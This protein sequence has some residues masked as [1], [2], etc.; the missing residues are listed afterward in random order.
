MEHDYPLAPGLAVRD[1][2]IALLVNHTT[3][4]ALA[5]LE[6]PDHL[7]RAMLHLRNELVYADD[8]GSN[9]TLRETSELSP[10]DCETL[11]RR[12]YSFLTTT[13]IPS[14]RRRDL[15]YTAITDFAARKDDRVCD[16][17]EAIVVAL[18][19]DPDGP[20]EHDDDYNYDDWV[21]DEP[22]REAEARG[23]LGT[24]ACPAARSGTTYHLCGSN[25]TA[26]T[27]GPDPGLW[28]SMSRISH[29]LVGPVNWKAASVGLPL[30]SASLMR[31]RMLTAV[32][33]QGRHAFT[34]ILNRLPRG[35]APLL[36]GAATGAA[37][38][39]TA[40][41]AAAALAA[42]TSGGNDT[43]TLPAECWTDNDPPDECCQGESPPEACC[44]AA[45]LPIPENCPDICLGPSCTLPGP[46]CEARPCPDDWLCCPLELS[47]PGLNGP[48]A[49]SPASSYAT[50]ISNTPT[51]WDQE[52]Q[53]A[54]TTAC[55]LPLGEERDRAFDHLVEIGNRRSPP[56]TQ[57][58]RN[59]IS[60]DGVKIRP[61][62]TGPPRKRPAPRRT[63]WHST[64][65]LTA[66]ASRR[67]RNSDHPRAEHNTRDSTTTT[68]RE[69][70]KRSPPDSAVLR[71]LARHPGWHIAGPLAL[72]DPFGI[73]RRLYRP[74]SNSSRPNG[75]ARRRR[76]VPDETVYLL[77][78]H[79]ARNPACTL[80]AL[81]LAE[82]LDHA[83]RT[84]TAS[85][86]R[87]TVRTVDKVQMAGARWL[88]QRG[89]KVWETVRTTFTIAPATTTGAEEVESLRGY[90]LHPATGK[91]VPRDPASLA[92]LTEA[93]QTTR[94]DDNIA[95]L[96]TLMKCMSSTHLAMDTD[97]DGRRKRQAPGVETG[98]KPKQPTWSRH[99]GKSADS[100]DRLALGIQHS[101]VQCGA[102]TF[103]LAVILHRALREYHDSEGSPDATCHLRDLIAAVD[104]VHWMTWERSQEGSEPC[105]VWPGVRTLLRYRE[106]TYSPPWE[107]PN[108]LPM[109]RRIL[110]DEADETR[111]VEHRLVRLHGRI[112][113]VY[114]KHPALNWKAARR[115][116]DLLENRQP[117]EQERPTGGDPP[118][119]PM[120]ES[121]DGTR[122]EKRTA[123]PDWDDDAEAPAAKRPPRQE[124]PPSSSSHNYIRPRPLQ[125]KGTP[126]PR[127]RLMPDPTKTTPDQTGQTTLQRFRRTPEPEP[128]AIAALLPL[129]TSVALGMA[130]PLAVS[131]VGT[132]VGVGVG[133]GIHAATG[134]KGLITG[135]ATDPTTHNTTT[136]ARRK[137]SIPSRLILRL[138]TQHPDLRRHLNRITRHMT[139]TTTHN[140][141]TTARRKRSIPDRLILRLL[142]QHPALRRHLIPV[143]PHISQWFAGMPT[144]TDIV[145]PANATPSDS[146]TRQKRSPGPD[147]EPLAFIPL[148]FGPGLSAPLGA[149]LTTIG[150]SGTTAG[151]YQLTDHLKNKAMET[152]PSPPPATTPFSAPAGNLSFLGVT[153][154]P[155]TTPPSLEQQR[156]EARS[157]VLAL[158]G[159]M[160]GPVRLERRGAPD[161][162]QP[163]EDE[164][165]NRTLLMQLWELI[166]FATA[167]DRLPLAR[168]AMAHPPE[169]LRDRYH[170]QLG[171][172]TDAGSH[173]RE[174]RGLG[175]LATLTGL[176]FKA[177][178]KL[179]W[180]V[181]KGALFGVATT[182]AGVGIHAIVQSHD[183]AYDYSDELSANIG[184]PCWKE[185]YAKQ[186]F[187]PFCGS[188]GKCCRLGWPGRGCN[189]LEGVNNTHVC[190]YSTT[191][192]IQDAYN[193][194]LVTDAALREMN[195][196][197]HRDHRQFLHQLYGRHQLHSG[198]IDEQALLRE[199]IRGY[200]NLPLFK[201]SPDFQA[202]VTELD[203]AIKAAEADNNNSTEGNGDPT[204][205][206]L[207]APGDGTKSVR[208]RVPLSRPRRVA[209]NPP[210][211]PLRF[212]Q[213]EAG[214][215]TDRYHLW[216][217]L[218]HNVRHRRD[219]ST[220][221]DD[222]LTVYT[223][224]NRVC[225]K[226]FPELYRDSLTRLT[227]LCS[228][229]NPWEVDGLPAPRPPPR[230][231]PH[232][233]PRRA[234]RS[235]RPVDLVLTNATFTG[236]I[237]RRLGGPEIPAAYWS[238]L[239]D[240]LL[241]TAR[242]PQH[243][244]GAVLATADGRM[245]GLGESLGE[246][247]ATPASPRM[248]KEADDFVIQLQLDRLL[249]RP[250]KE[251]ETPDQRT[252][253]Y[254]EEKFAR[255]TA[256]LAQDLTKVALPEDLVTRRIAIWT[257][258]DDQLSAL[259]RQRRDDQ[260]PSEFRL[261]EGIARLPS[262]PKPLLTL[263]LS[264]CLGPH[265]RVMSILHYLSEQANLLALN[266]QHIQWKNLPPAPGGAD[267]TK[268]PKAQRPRKHRSWDPLRFPGAEAAT[269]TARS[270]HWPRWTYG[271]RTRRD[272]RG[273]TEP[274]RTPTL[275]PMR[276]PQLI[277]KA[278][279]TAAVDIVY[280]PLPI[281]V[282]LEPMGK[283]IHTVSR[284]NDMHLRDLAR[285]HRISVPPPTTWR[286]ERPDLPPELIPILNVRE[287]TIRLGRRLGHLKA[288]G[289]PRENRWP[290]SILSDQ[291]EL[292]V[293]NNFVFSP[294]PQATAVR[295]HR[296]A[297][298]PLISTAQL[299]GAAKTLL[300]A[301]QNI[302]TTLRR[303]MQDIHATAT[304]P[305]K[306]EK[307]DAHELNT[308]ALLQVETALDA[309][310]QFV[311]SAT[312][313]SLHPEQVYRID[314]ADLRKLNAEEAAKGYEPLLR[315]RF[316]L[317]TAPTTVAAVR[318]NGEVRRLQVLVWLPYV[319]KSGRMTAYSV[320]PAPVPM[321]D[322]GHVTLAPD[323]ERIILVSR[324][325]RT[326]L[327]WTTL[328]A[329][330]FAA[331]RPAGTS[332]TC[333]SMGTL[334]PPIDDQAWPRQDAD[335]CAYALHARKP[336]L[337]LTACTRR[338]VH[339]HFTAHRLGPF[340]WVVFSQGV[341]T[342]QY[343]CPG[344]DPTRAQHIQ[345]LAILRLPARCRALADGWELIADDS[346]A[347]AQEP[348]VF[349]DSIVGLPAALG[350]LQRRDRLHP[351]DSSA[352]MAGYEYYRTG[353]PPTDPPPL[354]FIFGD[355]EATSAILGLIIVL[356]L[357]A[358]TN[359]VLF[360]HFRT[361][362]RTVRHELTRVLLGEEEE[363]NRDGI[364]RL[365]TVIHRIYARL[366]YTEAMVV[367]MC[368][369]L[370]RA[371]LRFQQ[372]APPPADAFR[373][374]MPGA[375]DVERL[376][377]LA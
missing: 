351:D 309:A 19:S 291:T 317:T 372:T 230:E 144:L 106:H 46:D 369:A 91:P 155:F 306:E 226:K 16:L 119:Q 207:K 122:G 358:A 293:V 312:H 37:L 103:T 31:N 131:A 273:D 159:T 249:D 53:E 74:A 148:L 315:S 143:T 113:P 180:T 302:F 359:A 239:I 218:I 270:E 289:S 304:R 88:D 98:T 299:E 271:G 166:S 43:D 162:E 186:G 202:A 247:T 63:A 51:D 323:Q 281:T 334:R 229:E 370:Q 236:N 34:R 44:D 105:A 316:E 52:Y 149:L 20:T 314:R 338:P 228:I 282:D 215:P 254:C 15:A 337:A 268:Q 111:P 77:A 165:K 185:C 48:L 241:A 90:I 296:A 172:A 203:N 194:I 170:Y 244:P 60:C 42:G 29:K 136:T 253:T 297:D 303:T 153:G 107:G 4:F 336:Q 339:E 330:E 175:P 54:R 234:T 360:C 209:E 311:A 368:A 272:A 179:G 356:L 100:R 267:R 258:D 333:P 108:M 222:K 11:G 137:R 3:D 307:W 310:S 18:F 256:Y 366:E 10:A 99:P 82:G 118:A 363:T 217:Q 354:G 161:P 284:I 377:L 350:H 191:S 371:K 132:A 219:T 181:G 40:A 124:A 196:T 145:K 146:S 301:A 138:L 133:A 66:G 340:S 184:I 326:E 227:Y 373:T 332:I 269:P 101:G 167:L 193:L 152:T 353:P 216:Q 126:R 361:R 192:N 262:Y 248:R 266:R 357:Q 17:P 80:L 245:R 329:T 36:A 260:T 96:E 50:A 276:E 365:A 71:M 364:T 92:I 140:T 78:G 212:P 214:V 94:E 12:L 298:H 344:V 24:H 65:N 117:W 280:K 127:P 35:K 67:R 259:S 56:M 324:H 232:H 33:H 176:L 237:A 95:D 8:D 30:I 114:R 112:S 264:R 83:M 352:A 327:S 279:G 188:E 235:V 168:Y 347:A 321:G 204:P 130:K 142:A 251:E 23:H 286:T 93:V 182:G 45:R 213:A 150:W 224:I 72:A 141:T 308:D 318:V 189:G 69:R 376:A 76:A 68:R 55:N 294:V 64:P 26:R 47:L 275:Q 367:N 84:R 102:T 240:Y 328:S 116:A 183:T 198:G 346:S 1:D 109:L 49:N 243:A 322:E 250:C 62:S 233:G 335:I 221:D 197:E 28:G 305:Q 201:N 21:H 59:A 2:E 195:G 362:F 9:P 283:T 320:V 252:V 79:D 208:V 169:S 345:G 355:T 187:C 263:A 277:H 97:E 139:D 349:T 135:H 313:G 220:P 238:L 206:A 374:T 110:N 70:G 278:M 61:H 342:P 199:Y 178:P 285:K 27:A 205:Q 32:A 223:V 300:P 292:D 57:A 341:T 343:D 75:S 242:S 121:A 210:W 319:H 134:N 231:L 257:A 331:C 128:F 348:A 261:C 129:I 120:E 6:L 211:D 225:E 200:G 171:A 39:P 156:E 89:C 123:D 7:F 287:R 85:H 173:H 295:A 160:K 158:L 177:A 125:R 86:M 190:T 25:R 288:V 290:R 375:P 255:V 87:F 325:G 14:Y 115:L 164:K 38:I 13:L 265:R 58:E 147:P 5:S 73:R 157:K 163:G 274:P 41:Q 104:G 22:Y 154:R 174:K 151:I 246:R 81:N